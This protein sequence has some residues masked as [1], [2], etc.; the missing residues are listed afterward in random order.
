MRSNSVVSMA[1]SVLLLAGCSKT[2]PREVRNFEDCAAAGNPVMESYP[3]QCKANGQTYIEEIEVMDETS[4]TEEEARKIAEETCIKGG[5]SL[6]TS[7][8]YN[9]NSK[10]WW[11]DAN[12][13]VTQPGCDPACVVSEETG[14]AEI[15]WRCTGLIQPDGSSETA[16]KEVF[17]RKY[18][19]YADTLS[20]NI[21]H[22][23]NGFARGNITFVQGQAGGY[24]F[25]KSIDGV[26]QIVLDGNGGI[27][28][29]LSEQGFPASMLTDCYLY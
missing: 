17:I 12:L 16:I 26:W 3:R 4:M 8:L 10:T 19:K 15:N 20:V 11:F 25:A 7:G 2:I 29:K 5:D 9:P 18:P 24:F 22:E 23:E 14:M 13:N 28:C 21:L 1:L 6:E 27:P